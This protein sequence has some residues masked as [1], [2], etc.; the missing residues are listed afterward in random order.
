[1]SE[2]SLLLVGAGGH[3]RAC[4]DVIEAEGR[5]QVGGVVGLPPEVGRQLLDYPIIGSDQDLAALLA[6][7]PYAFI[8]VGQIR[9][10]QARMRL[11][12]ELL[13]LGFELP[14]I[15][16][17]LARVSRHAR[18]GAGTIV[19]HGALIN[20]GAT[21]GRNCIINSHALIEHDAVIADHCHVS[22]AAVI[23]GAVTVG[24]GTFIGSNATVREAVR[25]GEQC[26]IGMGERV[27]ADCP[28]GTRP[29]PRGPEVAA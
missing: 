6:R 19:M 24:E 12:A 9:S 29:L 17:P 23:N 1:M 4:L 2:A 7:H 18:L 25:I 10:A 5:F 22:T 3:A 13:R 20:S 11:F 26:V 14:V 8:T 21:V 27:H 28:P 16:S 15:V